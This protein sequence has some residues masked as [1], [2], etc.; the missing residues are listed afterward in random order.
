MPLQGERE[1]PE[2]ALARSIA[3]RFPRRIHRRQEQRGQDAN[4]RN[5]YE[6]FHEGEAGWPS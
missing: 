2:I 3:C 4:D 6:H 5:H 1:L